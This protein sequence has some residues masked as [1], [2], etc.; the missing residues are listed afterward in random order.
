[1]TKRPPDAWGQLETRLKELI[2]L[3]S[4]ISLLNWDQAVLM[5][6]KGAE[7][8]ARTTATMEALAHDRL[9]DPAIGE[10]LEELEQADLDIDRRASVR[11]LRRDYDK[12][13]KVPRDLVV[14]IATAQAGAYH[15]WTDA[16]PANDFSILEPHLKR[17]V[18]LKREEADALGW[19]EERYDA[20]LDHFEPGMTAREVSSIFDELIAGLKPLNEAILDAVDA[21]PEWLFVEFDVGNQ[22]SFCRWLVERLEFDVDG[23][24]LD[25]SPHPFTAQIAS[26]DVRQTTRW[27]EKAFLTSIYAAI[28]ETG[29]ALYEQGIPAELRD[30]PVGGAPSLGMHESQSRLWEN[31][32]GRSRAFTAFL[33]P[34]LKERWPDQIGTVEP[35]DFYRAVNHP[36]RTLIR[37]TADELTYNLHV[38]LRLRL[39]LA[40]FR[41]DLS[42]DELPGAWDEASSE[43]IGIRSETQS[44]GVLQDM[45]WS[46]GALGYFPTY[47]LGN[48]YAAAFYA[49]ATEELGDLDE[50]LRA[51]EVGRL[52]KWLRDKIHSEAYRYDAKELAERVVGGPVSP[53][54]LLDYLRD[55]YTELYGASV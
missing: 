7:A 9:T 50:E 49:K 38:A 36:R 20:L 21:P 52:L 1:M 53:R 10:L 26:G 34:H 45:H 22:A 51:G 8:R 13:V 6:P 12:A 47:T 37:V 44:D 25:S 5:P 28:H 35:D 39:E 24:R 3:V 16:R 29:H 32:V 4:A 23:G 27:E 30:W 48:I 18:D 11:I 41:G 2:D 19:E 14:A 40:L 31:Q 33:L 43:M 17:V 15:A 55:K 46:T 54:P 42:V